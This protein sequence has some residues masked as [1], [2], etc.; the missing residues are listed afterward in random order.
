MFFVS[1]N[2]IIVIFSHHAENETFLKTD[3]TKKYRLLD[4]KIIFLNFIHN[5]IR[6][7]RFI[8][9][10]GLLMDYKKYTFIKYINS[11]IWHWLT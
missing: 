1:S 9:K 3:T 8:I 5:K 2:F 10:H 11:P 6:T 7:K 4:P